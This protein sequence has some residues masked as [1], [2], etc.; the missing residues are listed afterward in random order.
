MHT[1]I[2]THRERCT[3]T[4]T[5][6][7]HTHYVMHTLRHAQTRTH[8]RTYAETGY[9][10]GCSSQAISWTTISISS[11]SRS[12]SSREVAKDLSIQGRATIMRRRR[13]DFFFTRS[14][15][16]KKKTT[17]LGEATDTEAIRY[18]WWWYHGKRGLLIVKYFCCVK[19]VLNF[20]SQ[21]KAT[22]KFHF[23][24]WQTK[25]RSWLVSSCR[26]TQ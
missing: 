21:I 5:E 23:V 22:K 14:V 9:K 12:S 2:Y 15:S 3:N 1:P 6:K 24:S 4:R 7:T 13:A 20:I 26:S 19:C 18:L 25:E 8:A 10:F 11:S 16:K 17:F